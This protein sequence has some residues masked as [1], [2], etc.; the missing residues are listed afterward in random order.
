MP[1]KSKKPK[2]LTEL[3]GVGPAIADKLASAGFGTVEALAAALPQEI[4]SVT[5]LSLSASQRL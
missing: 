4:A 3:P 5:G 1:E 2:E